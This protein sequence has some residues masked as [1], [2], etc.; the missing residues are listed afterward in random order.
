MT[1]DQGGFEGPGASSARA[2]T[3]R[4]HTSPYQRIQQLME[5]EPCDSAKMARFVSREKLESTCVA[6]SSSIQLGE[7][8]KHVA[9]LL[10][11]ILICQR[12]SAR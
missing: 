5:E 8:C 4:L 6:G 7:F 1:I 10:A 12:A 3:I 11:Y 9:E 2:Y